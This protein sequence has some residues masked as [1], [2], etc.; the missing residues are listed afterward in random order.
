MV[1][2][3]VFG[4]YVIYC[5]KDVELRVAKTIRECILHCEILRVAVGSVIVLA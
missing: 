1:R 2:S 3:K 4:C 5:I